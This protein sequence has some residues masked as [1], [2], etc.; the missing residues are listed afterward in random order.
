MSSRSARSLNGEGMRQPAR[1]IVHLELHT[2]DLASACGFYALVCG[3]RPERIEAGGS[4]YLVL[5]T[6]GGIGGGIVECATEQAVW[7]PY[8]EVQN[9]AQ[10]TALARLAGGSVL[11]EPREGP[12]GWRSVV[13]APEGTEVGLF[14]PKDRAAMSFGARDGLNARTS[15]RR[16][17]KGRP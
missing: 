11:L 16:N 9:V 13:A 6:G 10:A 7:L 8:V 4:S 12:A 2:R 3:W 5:D 1:P 17:G 14:Q 15:N